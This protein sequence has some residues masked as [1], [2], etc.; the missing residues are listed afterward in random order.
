MRSVTTLPKPIV[1][2]GYVPAKSPPALE[3]ITI[4]FEESLSPRLMMESFEIAMP[5]PA[6]YTLPESSDGTHAVPF[7]FSTWPFVAPI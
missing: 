1:G 3:P 7:H 5:S 4:S 6:L 2:F